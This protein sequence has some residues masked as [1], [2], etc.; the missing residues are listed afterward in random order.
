MPPPADR[1]SVGGPGLLWV[2]E[3]AALVAGDDYTWPRSYYTDI[4][5]SDWK[6]PQETLALLVQPGGGLQFLAH[7]RRGV[8][9]AVRIR[10]GQFRRQLGLAGG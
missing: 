4:V 6:L 5:P 9:V 7:C 2:S 1:I 8:K 3:D 10:M